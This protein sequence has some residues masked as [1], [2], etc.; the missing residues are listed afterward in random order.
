MLGY[1]CAE[2][3]LYE[4][5]RW[6]GEEQRAPKKE[7]LNSFRKEEEYPGRS[8]DNNHKYLDWVINLDSM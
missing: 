8:I 6:R 4:E 1:L 3:Y 7:Q 5:R 2:V